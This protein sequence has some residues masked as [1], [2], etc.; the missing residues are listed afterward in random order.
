MDKLRVQR[1]IRHKVPTTA[2][3]VIEDGDE[4]IVYIER[5]EKTELASVLDRL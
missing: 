5:K 4:V 2:D 1:Y 3:T